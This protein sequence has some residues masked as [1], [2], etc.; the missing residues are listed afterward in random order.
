MEVLTAFP[1]EHA[2][3]D[4]STGAPAAVGKRL[5][6]D[7]QAIATVIGRRRPEQDPDGQRLELSETDLSGVQWGR[8]SLR[9]A[10]LHRANLTGAYLRWAHLEGAGLVG[11]NLSNARL[12]RAYLGEARLDGANLNSAWL[13]EYRPVCLAGPDLGAV[14]GRG[15][16]ARRISARRPCAGAGQGHQRPDCTAL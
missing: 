10:N 4:T 1:R 6:V 12:E 3:F 11:T 9:G 2:P 13:A 16:L 14:A 15:R 5:A 8:P 7:D